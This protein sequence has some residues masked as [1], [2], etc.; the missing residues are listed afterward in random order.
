VSGV[1]IA[2]AGVLAPVGDA[3][4]Y[5][6]ALQLA[7]DESRR[8]GTIA[9]GRARASDYSAAAITRRYWAVIERALERTA[10][11]RTS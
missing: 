8:E 6:R 11:A 3:A 2:D 5:A 4:S 9:A 10:E 7:F 1:T